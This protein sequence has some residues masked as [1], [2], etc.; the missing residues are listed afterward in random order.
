MLQPG[1]TRGAR[2]R[3][4]T[5]LR[6]CWVLL[7]SS[8]ASG[9]L[10]TKAQIH[11]ATDLLRG[12]TFT[13]RTVRGDGQT[14]IFTFYLPSLQCKVVLLFFPR[15]WWMLKNFSPLADKRRVRE[16]PGLSWECWAPLGLL[17]QVL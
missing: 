8:L 16:V 14:L 10:G 15:S 12:Q 3:H 6:H 4:C 9:L 1:L 2:L 5:P 11:K 7:V 17:L 13:V